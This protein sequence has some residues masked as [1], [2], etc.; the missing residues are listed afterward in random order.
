[1]SKTNIL[2]SRFEGMRGEKTKYFAPKTITIQMR[3][4]ET[5]NLYFLHFFTCGQLSLD[6]PVTARNIFNHSIF[7]RMTTLNEFL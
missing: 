3:T 4:K 6:L 2:F 1:M 5:Q 7:D